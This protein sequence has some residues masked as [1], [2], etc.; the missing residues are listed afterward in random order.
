MSG[1][2]YSPMECR[3]LSLATSWNAVG[4]F[5]VAVLAAVA[6]IGAVAKAMP[7]YSHYSA[8]QNCRKVAD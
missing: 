6:S 7:V 4:M 8:T 2:K 5:V 1:S 3:K